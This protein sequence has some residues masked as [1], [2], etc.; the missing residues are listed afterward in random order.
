MQAEIKLPVEVF[1]GLLYQGLQLLHLRGICR[2]YWRIALLG[3]HGNV[4]HADGGLR[5]AQHELRALFVRTL[6]HI[7]RN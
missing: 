5:I 7:P 4:T 2:Y 1:L 3:Q 6:R